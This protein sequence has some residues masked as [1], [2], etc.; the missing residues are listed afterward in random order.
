MNIPKEILGN[1]FPPNDYT[2]PTLVEIGLALKSIV[3]KKIP[4]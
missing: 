1:G 4:D 3:E 2:K